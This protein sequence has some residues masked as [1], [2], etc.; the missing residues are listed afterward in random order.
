MEFYK[1]KTGYVDVTDMYS[2]LYEAGVI[3]FPTLKYN[4]QGNYVKMAQSMLS[5]I[6]PNYNNMT[7]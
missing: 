3:E 2:S 5:I 7:C 6:F 4:S 1:T